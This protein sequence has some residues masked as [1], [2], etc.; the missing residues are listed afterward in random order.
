MAESQ[1]H[2]FKFE[3]YVL[4]NKMI[5]IRKVFKNSIGYNNEWDFPPISIKSFKNEVANPII[6]FG[7]IERI[8]SNSDSYLLFLIGY[9]QKNNYK[10]PNFSDILFIQKKDMIKLKGDLDIATIKLLNK[11]IKSF[12]E[13][14]HEEAREWAKKQKEIYNSKTI[15]DIRFKIDSKKQ[16]RIQCALKLKDLYNKT[17]NNL[18]L[19]NKY[20]IPGIY[21]TKRIRNKNSII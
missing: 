13:K 19:N 6:E 1:E 10:I 2:G 3:E 4:D 17:N 5:E 14:K 11:K 16:R 9:I 20:N 12:K 21:S 18:L 15:Y 8:F 7:S